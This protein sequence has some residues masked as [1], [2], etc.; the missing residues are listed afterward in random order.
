[1]NWTVVGG[2]RP[3]VDVDV[4]D[5]FGER[6]SVFE[7]NG[8]IR[9]GDIAGAAYEHCLTA[10][11]AQMPLPEAEVKSTMKPAPEPLKSP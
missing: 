8:H 6:C 1:M 4:K 2:G 7:L 3:L 10:A 11:N 9:K 5:K